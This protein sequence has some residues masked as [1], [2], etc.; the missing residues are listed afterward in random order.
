MKISKMYKAVAIK[1]FVIN[2]G[3]IQKLDGRC[4]G[5]ST[6]D[7]LFLIGKAMRNPSMPYYLSESCRTVTSNPSAEIQ[8]FA[9]TVLAL[10]SE[11]KLDY[12]KYD[13]KNKFISY[14]IFYT[15][16]ELLDSL[17]QK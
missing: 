8:H 9:D 11:L 12:F 1:N 5:A 14:E 7:A 4:S 10:I 3:S 15:E 17:C 16:A 6:G 13:K 2:Q